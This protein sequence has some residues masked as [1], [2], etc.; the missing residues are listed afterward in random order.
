[1]DNLYLRQTFSIFSLNQNLEKFSN[2]F[3]A[4]MKRLI[5]IVIDSDDRRAPKTDLLASIGINSLLELV[6]IIEPPKDERIYAI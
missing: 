5:A 6:F 4:T 1:M 2:L 3:N